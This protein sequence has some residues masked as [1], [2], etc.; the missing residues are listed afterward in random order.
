[1][2]K[3]L[4]SI[5]LIDDDKATNVYNSA[6]V[7]QATVTDQIDVCHSGEDALQFLKTVIDGNHPQPSLIFLDGLPKTSLNL[8]A[9]LP[10]GISF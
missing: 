7:N 5:L 8:F 3:K 6:I 2:K 10:S 9:S 1:M 4:N